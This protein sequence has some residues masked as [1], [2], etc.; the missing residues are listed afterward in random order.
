MLCEASRT[1]GLNF[2]RPVGTSSSF[3]KYEK[4]LVSFASLNSNPLEAKR[5]CSSA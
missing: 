3:R 5:T 4:V 1:S 2:L